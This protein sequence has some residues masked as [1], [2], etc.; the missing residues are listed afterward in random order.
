MTRLEQAEKTIQKLAGICEY[1]GSTRGKEMA[2]KYFTDIYSF[3]TRN[4]LPLE[5]ADGAVCKHYHEFTGD[6]EYFVP[7]FTIG[8]N[9]SVRA[10]L[11]VLHDMIDKLEKIAATPVTVGIRNK[12]IDNVNYVYPSFYYAD[13]SLSCLD[14]EGNCWTIN[15]PNGAPVIVQKY[16]RNAA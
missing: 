15:T 12:S 8:S 3:K 1:L 2:D 5:V 4:I 6:N 11:D 16:I 7:E 14:K 13:Y 9:D 10:V